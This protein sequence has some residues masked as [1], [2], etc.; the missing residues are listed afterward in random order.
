MLSVCV[1]VLV[2]RLHHKDPYPQ[3]PAWL[4]HLL[5]RKTVGNVTTLIKEKN[6]SMKDLSGDQ[7]ESTVPKANAAWDDDGDNK[8]RNS[9]KWKEVASVVNTISF[10]ML[11]SAS[12]FM[13]SI[14]AVSWC[15]G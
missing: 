8:N 11:L 12:L 7:V 10:F 15:M 1:T 13:Y 4:Q 5:L 3:P 9:E 14:C 2:L 6:M